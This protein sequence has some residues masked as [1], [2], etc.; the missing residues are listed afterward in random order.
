MCVC[1]CVCVCVRVYVCVCVHVCARMLWYKQWIIST[2][3]RARAPV[4]S[5]PMQCLNTELLCIACVRPLT[6][7]THLCLGAGNG[8]L[9]LTGELMPSKSD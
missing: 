2:G 8:C 6:S 5:S 7:L 1:A 4:R 3:R 9:A